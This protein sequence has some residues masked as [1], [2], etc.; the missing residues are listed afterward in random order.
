MTQSKTNR[1]IALDVLRGMTVAGM[2]MVNNP[3]SWAHV[4]PPLRHAAWNGCTPCDLVFPFFLFCV[5]T[6]M[7]FSFSKYK[8]GLNGQSIKKILVR[9]ILIFLVGLGLNTFP[10]FPL[11]PQESLTF[12][13]NYVHWLQN[14]RIMGVLQ[15]IAI[16]YVIGGIL[17]L[18]LNTAKRI[19]IGMCSLLAIHSAIS[20]I[21]GGSDWSTLQ[22]NITA[23]IDIAIFGENHLYH[24]YEGLPFDPE[25][26]LGSISGAGTVLLGFLIGQ[27]IQKTPSKIDVV[28]KLYT[29]G[30]IFLGLGCIMSI[31]IPINKSLW[32]SSYVFYTGGWA[33]TMLA[34]FI[35]FIDVKEK[36]KPFTVFKALGMNPLFLFVL[37]GLIARIFG[38]LG[39]LSWFYNNCC[40][41][42]FGNNQFGSL[43]YALVFVGVFCL[44][45]LWLYRKKIVIK[46]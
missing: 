22:G 23:H 29:L 18:W 12:G 44:T 41:S 30:L 6:A 7:A 11:Y 35:Y 34:L 39:I 27:T 24:G 37:A 25:G 13:E 1:Y 43:F 8:E 2:I 16:C 21:F 36:A 40:V 28:A 46:L 17:A 33:T 38:K 42:I 9:G 15:R 3:G 26:L 19:I 10:F 5:G 45:G 31:W 14:I 20:I 32:S 4:F